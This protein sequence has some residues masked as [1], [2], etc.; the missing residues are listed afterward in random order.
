[1]RSGP[2]F[3]LRPSSLGCSAA[4]PRILLILGASSLAHLRENLKTA[5]LAMP[6]ATF[7]ELNAIGRA[8]G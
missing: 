7:A 3:A 2:L 8:S 4:R 1:V 5:E 6:D